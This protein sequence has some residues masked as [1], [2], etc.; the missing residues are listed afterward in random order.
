MCGE[1]EKERQPERKQED[2]YET[3]KCERDTA[4]LRVLSG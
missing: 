1:G 2:A 3:E 4:R